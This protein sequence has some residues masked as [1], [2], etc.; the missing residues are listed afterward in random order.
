MRSYANVMK[1]LSAVTESVRSQMCGSAKPP[2]RTVAI[3]GRCFSVYRRLSPRASAHLPAQANAQVFV[4]QVQAPTQR[5]ASIAWIW[6]SDA[7]TQYE[8]VLS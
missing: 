5:G 3:H 6:Q 7:T 4:S 8:Y 2:R 1:T